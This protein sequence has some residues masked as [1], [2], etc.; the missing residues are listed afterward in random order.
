MLSLV[1]PIK[2][3][4]PSRLFWVNGRVR[5]TAKYE[6]YLNSL[7]VLIKQATARTKL[8]D[9]DNFYYVE[10]VFVFKK[11]LKKGEPNN[12]TSKPDLD[13]LLKPLF[14]SL[15]QSGIIKDDSQFGKLS[16]S[17]IYDS[18]DRITINLLTLNDYLTSN[19]LSIP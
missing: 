7:K 3:Q 8:L 16:A 5:N 18:E 2:P 9:K 12:H 1:L 10:V 4:S 6:S 11:V 14:D 13:N 19:Q 15:T 17:K